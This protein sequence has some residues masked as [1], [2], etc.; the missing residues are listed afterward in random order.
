MVELGIDGWEWLRDLYE[1]KEASPVDGNDLQDEETDVISHVIIGRPVI[2]IRNCD[3]S[4]RI[5]YGRLSNMG[6]SA[7]ALHPAVFPLLNYFIV[8]GS[9]L[10][11]NLPGKGGIVVPSNICSPPIV[12]LDNG[13]VVRLETEV[14]ARKYMKKIRKVLF[15][16]DI[17]ISVGDFL[18]NNYDLVPS[19]YTEEWWYQDL[20][21]ALNKPK[22]LFSNLNISSP[23]DF[24]NF[25]DAY[26]LS[27]TLNIPLH[28]RYIYRWNRLKVEEVIY[29]IKKI[30]E[31]GK[32]NKEGNL[33]IK[34]DEVIKSHLEK[35]L[36]PHKIRGKSI[37]I[38]DKNDVNLLI[39]IISNYFLKEE[40]SLNDAIKVN[41]SLDFVGKLMGVKLLDVE[42]E[43]IDARLGRPEKVKPRETSPPIHVLF[44]ISKYG[45]S[46]RDLIKASEDQRY[47]IVSLAIRYCSKCKIYT[48]KIFCPHCRSR[49]TQKRYCRSCKYVVDR[50]SCPQCG[51]E[52]IFTK[53]FTIDIKAL[54]NDFSKKLGV[55]V[56]KDLKGVEG[57]LN[58]FAISEDLA[59]G[60]IRAINNIYIFKDGTSRI[61]VT[62]APLHQFRVKDI[63]ITVNEARLLGYEVKNEDE[64]LDLYPQDIIIP[65]T[66][67]KYLINVARYLDE[68]LEKV[69]GLKP[70]YNIKKYKDLL[71]HLVIGLSPHT[72]VGIIGRIIGFTSSS[73]L[74]AHPL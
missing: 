39:L 31:F 46:K 1:S 42:G 64:I 66:A 57:L 9:Q 70:Y 19:P 67:A 23:Y 15:L 26:L 44:P 41:Q 62:N 73:V 34:Y 21:D 7:V 38:G 56:P 55:N 51:R 58:K 8:I 24:I 12:L 49:T 53:P 54:I 30:G 45:G 14:D 33:I 25:H 68:L 61:D 13:S 4:L 6:L 60:I 5:R 50:E 3:A 74:Y 20:L 40:N 28:P 37:I 69:Y 52:T 16:G 59:K 29:L 47:I 36:I 2:S 22:G 17:M 43:K 63:G 27:R 35:L 72:S 65:Y 32:I 18:E 71:G 10:K 11:L 48:Y